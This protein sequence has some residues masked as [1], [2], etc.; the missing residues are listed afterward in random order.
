MLNNIAGGG[1]AISVLAQELNA[2]LEVINLGTVHDP[3]ILEGVRNIPLGSGTANFLN[4]PAMT[5]RQLAL[6]LQE[7]RHSAERAGHTGVQLYIG[8][9]LGIGNTTSAAALAC[10]LLNER[11]EN[12]T[13][14]GTGLDSAGVRSKCEIIRQALNYHEM[15]QH[16][17][18]EALRCL[19]G[20][21]IAAL[22]GAYLASAKQALPLLVDGFIASTAALIAERLCPG[23]AHWFLH[24]HHSAEPG[25]ASIL[26]ALGAQ[27]MLDLGMR[28]G[29]GSGAAAT[30]PVLRM[31]CA[32]HNRMATFSQA[33]VS[34]KL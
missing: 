14:P 21:E 30:V 32:L 8:G 17:P 31:A 1:A 28:L 18:L 20:F 13:G 27:P 11:P 24:A 7:G 9:E 34:V 25:H 26:K 29:E 12:V 4:G 10:V 15:S 16:R 3:G 33:K 22:V 23:T 6:A 5:E 19:G 2:G